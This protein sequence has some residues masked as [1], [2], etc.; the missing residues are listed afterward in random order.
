MSLTK[1]L[2]L[3]LILTLLASIYVHQQIRILQLAYEEQEKLASLRNLLDEKNNLRYQI[4]RQ[5]SLVSIGNI[6]QNGEFEWPHRKQLVRLSTQQETG[7]D[8]ERTAESGS[9]FSRFIQLR[10]Q[11][12]ATP[13][14]PR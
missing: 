10:S 12:E 13:V 14:L 9:I 8:N 1:F 7:E 5:T 2:I 11:A 3:V 6:W 4:N